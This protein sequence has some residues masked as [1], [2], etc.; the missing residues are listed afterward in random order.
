MISCVIIED[1]IP[2]QYIIEKY[3]SETDNLI[4]K[5][6][7]TDP[8]AAKEY[9]KNE[10][11][12][13]IFL[14]IHLPKMSGI[15][16]LRSMENGPRVVLTTAFSDYAFES[17]ELNVLD[18]LLKPISYERF[19]RAI[20]KIPLN[21]KVSHDEFI[22]LKTGHE[23]IKINSA[24]IKYINSDSDYTEVCTID[25][26]HLSKDSLKQWL[27]RLNPKFFCQIHKSY[28]VNMN[29]LERISGNVVFLTNTELP[30]G[31]SFK[32][33]FMNRFQ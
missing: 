6:I 1:Q 27:E 15:E 17:Y 12:D 5:E 23:H 11:I 13:L 24:D 8:I 19:L 32:K 22:I 14:D 30:I 25:K 29:H 33:N 7:F 31:R 20:L 2:A 28:L 9:L 10:T 3:I 4:L 26:N 16:F 18:Y 21:D